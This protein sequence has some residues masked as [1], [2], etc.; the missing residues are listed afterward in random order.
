KMYDHIKEL[1][2]EIFNIYNIVFYLMLVLVIALVR[3][4][5][6]LL[7]LYAPM[8]VAKYM[9]LPLVSF[10]VP[11]IN[12]EGE[13][14]NQRVPLNKNT[15]IIKS[16]ATND[17]RVHTRQKLPE[18]IKLLPVDECHQSL[19]YQ[20]TDLS[21]RHLK[22]ANLNHVVLCNIN[23]IEADLQGASMTWSIFSGHFDLADM[24]GANLS[25]SQIQQHSSLVQTSL[26]GADLSYL[27]ANK[28]NFTMAD[29]SHAN[30]WASELNLTEFLQAKLVH[31]NFTLAQTNFTNFRNADFS[32]SHFN[33]TNLHGVDLRFAKNFNHMVMFDNSHISDCYVDDTN[34]L[35]RVDLYHQANCDIYNSNLLEEGSLDQEYIAQLRTQFKANDSTEFAKNSQNS[36]VLIERIIDIAQLSEADKINLSNLALTQIPRRVTALQGLKTLNLAYNHLDSNQLLTTTLLPDLTALDF[37]ANAAVI[38]PPEIAKLS[39]LVSLNLSTNQLISLPADFKRLQ[40]LQKLN[41]SDNLFS[42]LPSSVVQLKQLSSLNLRGNKLTE[43]PARIDQL[44]KLEML[45]F[46]NN[47]LRVVPTEIGQLTRLSTLDLSSNELLVLP[48]R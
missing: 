45:S 23:L 47:Q 15:D 40:N 30:I 24:S 10:I 7:C 6:L 38:V 12:I 29:L 46:A 41:I 18:G 9:D 16:L 33:Q 4:S 11:H 2:Y 1:Y 19:E 28:V 8:T 22:L 42:S 31:A 17:P 37:A 44:S 34:V 43:F 20:P 3:M 48:L 13:I 27:R 5:A 36:E 32:N 39:Q 14:I 26:V 21:E 25:H 35:K